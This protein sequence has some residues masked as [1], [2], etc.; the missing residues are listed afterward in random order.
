MT[1]RTLSLLLILLGLVSLFMAGCATNPVTGRQQ[2]MLVPESQAIS[3]SRQAY[4]QML[5]PIRE[6]GRL[7]SDPAVKARIDRITGRVVAQAIA[8]RPETRNWE[9]EMQVIDNDVPNAFAMAG[10]KMGIYTGMITKLNA[11]DD[12]LAQV[13][14]HE[15]AHALSAHTAEKMSVALATNLAVAGFALSGERSQVAMTGAVLA[16]ALAVQLPNSRQMER[17]ADVIGIELAARAGYDP[18]AAVTLWQKMAA[19]ANGSPPQFLSTHPSTE[20][21]IRDLQQLAVRMQPLYEQARAG[22]PPSHPL[23]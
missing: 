17:E 3:A 7:N 22:T 1:K 5:A 13:I 21:R 11:T 15:V 23:K 9:W 19:L 2:L 12:E 14:A 18:R 6:E 16:A 4:A 10:G 8:Y 20:S